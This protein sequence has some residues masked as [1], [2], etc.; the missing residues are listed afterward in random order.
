MHS[1]SFI[2]NK[3]MKISIW[4]IVGIGPIVSSYCIT[5]KWG[6][7]NLF[8]FIMD[9]N[10]SGAVPH[11]EDSTYIASYCCYYWSTIH[12]G[13]VVNTCSLVVISSVFYSDFGY[14]S[15]CK[16]VRTVTY[17]WLG[18]NSSYDIISKCFHCI[19]KSIWSSSHNLVVTK[20]MIFIIQRQRI[21]ISFFSSLLYHDISSDA[22]LI[23]NKWT[24]PNNKSYSKAIEKT[25]DGFFLNL[26]LVTVM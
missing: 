5:S 2:L 1:F 7:P 21:T 26:L 8:T 14:C 23:S 6:M 25:V 20:D 3:W 13:Y 24:I 10:L 9:S 4:F 16:T 17:I 15:N 12:M 18:F 22:M 11:F 19:I